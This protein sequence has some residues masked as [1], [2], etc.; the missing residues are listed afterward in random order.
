M[1]WKNRLRIYHIY[2]IGLLTVYIITIYQD[3]LHGGIQ[4]GIYRSLKKMKILM[5]YQWNDGHSGS[6]TT[7]GYKWE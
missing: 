6:S 1:S 7:M 3:N 4:L 5:N 2:I